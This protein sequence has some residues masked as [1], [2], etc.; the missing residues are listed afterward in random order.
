MYKKITT[1]FVVQK[2]RSF[3]GECVDQEFVAGDQ[4]DYEDMFGNSIEPTDDYHPFDMEQ[5]NALVDML[6]KMCHYAQ[7]HVRCWD[8]ES[9]TVDIETAMSSTSHAVASFICKNTTGG[10][11][12]VESDIV[13][14][15]LCQPVKE[16]DEWKVIIQE[17]F[18]LYE[19]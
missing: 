4:C 8:W 18:D 19:D 6:A 15:Q 1:G 10:W 5:P 16:V 17:L 12:G 2:F 13:I 11:S 7:S 3:N 14:D 9:S